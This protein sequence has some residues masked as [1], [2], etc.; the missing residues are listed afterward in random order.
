[1][2]EQEHMRRCLIRQ[3]LRWRH[4]RGIDWF[5]SYV[6]GWKR[7]DELRDDFAAQWQL[8]NRGAPNDWRE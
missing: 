1:M 3:L 8:G 6:D 5:R 2:D 4:E 7:W